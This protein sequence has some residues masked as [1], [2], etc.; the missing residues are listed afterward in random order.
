[1]TIRR[2]RSREL[3]ERARELMPGGVSSPV[4]AFKP[5]PSFIAGGKGSRILD[6]D[7][8]EYI[9]YCM[10]FGPLILGHADPDVVEAVREQADRGMLYGAPIEAEIEMAEFIRDCFPSVDMVRMV[11]SGTEAT[12]H[13][14]RLARGFTSRNKIIK[15]EGAFHGAHDSVLVRAGSGATTHGAP[16][17]PGIPRE[18]THNT[19]LVPFNDPYTMAEVIGKNRKEMA[20]V[21]LEPLGLG[22][23]A[24]A[25]R[26]EK[27]DVHRPILSDPCRAGGPS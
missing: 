23:L 3:F 5:Y 22:A 6:V 11:N 26:P 2:E 13:A 18:V 16:D 10:G 21:L 4:R 17:S 7:G 12:M 20:A 24:G 8:N 19:L 1:L 14:I 15:I 25:R 9:D 27:D